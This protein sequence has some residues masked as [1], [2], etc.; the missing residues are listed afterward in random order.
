MGLRENVVDFDEM[1]DELIDRLDRDLDLHNLIR[2]CILSLHMKISILRI[3]L[4]SMTAWIV[5]GK[6]VCA[7]HVVIV[8]K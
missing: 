5:F 6:N 4:C 2:F 8:Y 7:S 1:S 3:L